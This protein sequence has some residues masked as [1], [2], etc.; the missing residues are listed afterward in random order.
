MISQ[1]L[2]IALVVG[3]IAAQDQLDSAGN[4]MAPINEGRSLAGNTMAPVN[5]GLVG[6]T[7]A[8]RAIVQNV[9]PPLNQG[10]AVSGVG[11]TKAPI[12]QG[13]SFVENAGEGRALI[14]N[15]PILKALAGAGCALKE[16]PT[17]VKVIAKPDEFFVA[18]DSSAGQKESGFLVELLDII[19]K[20]TGA[21]FT[22][23]AKPELSYGRP[24]ENGTWDG[25]L[26][27][28]LLNNEA[29]LVGPSMTITSFGK[30]DVDYC[31]PI[32]PYKLHILFN[33][34]F[35]LSSGV[36]YLIMDDEDLFYLKNSKDVALQSI[37]QNIQAGRPQS[38][39]KNNQKVSPRC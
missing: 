14:P 5:E 3:R 12:S 37:Y 30:K 31:V 25:T 19:Q 16:W 39:V 33:P 18:A 20:A 1:L 35:G 11:I 38:I 23:T 2:A 21:V 32:L 15:R 27:A 17:N 7:M 4:T 6:N 29:D 36:Q 34:K 28:P 22:V 8:P 9:M 13:R 24:N 26:I 10:R